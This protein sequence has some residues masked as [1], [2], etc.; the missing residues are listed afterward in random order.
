MAAKSHREKKQIAT[1]VFTPEQL[2]A[3]V[4]QAAQMDPKLIYS[5]AGK[6]TAQRVRDNGS[7]AGAPL[8]EPV[9]CPKCGQHV[10]KGNLSRWRVCPHDGS[11][12]V[13]CKLCGKK[14][15]ALKKSENPHCPH[16]P[17]AE[18]LTPKEKV[19]I[20][21]QLTAERAAKVLEVVEAAGS[22]SAAAVKLKMSL[23]NVNRLVKRATHAQQ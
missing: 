17:G 8:Q 1:M 18:P 7:R 21:Q 6:L 4:Q 16:T 19:A 14:M 2:K 10:Q 12:K 9:L 15:T 5:E 11:N 13:A 20:A 3:A 23:S 22:Q